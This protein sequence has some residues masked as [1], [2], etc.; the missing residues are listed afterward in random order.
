MIQ[1]PSKEMTLAF[2]MPG[3]RALGG[4]TVWSLNTAREAAREGWPT[5]LIEHTEMDSR[6]PSVHFKDHPSTRIIK[7]DGR[8][9]QYARKRDVRNFTAAYRALLPAIIIPN[10]SY[11]TY[12]TVARLI[13]SHP[14]K[15]RILGVAHGINPQ[16]LDLLAYYESMIPQFVAVSVEVKDELSKRLP[17]RMDDI[18][19]RSCPVDAPD[20]LSRD[21]SREPDPIR[22]LYAGRLTDYEKRVS[23]L[24]PLAE[25]LHLSGVNFCLRVAGIGGYLETLKAE[26]S[27]AEQDV[28]SRIELLGQIEPGSMSDVWKESDVFILVSD[29]EGSP[30]AML[31]A[32]ANGC[33]PVVM[34]V[35][36][37]RAVI[38]PYENGLIVSS[39]DLAGMASAIQNLASRREQLEQFGEKARRSVYPAYAYKAYMPWFFDLV[40]R[41]AA[42]PPRE[43]FSRI[44]TP[45]L[46]RPSLVQCATARFHECY[47]KLKSRAG[48]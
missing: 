31:E 43:C 48:I 44:Q 30:V 42:S 23:R 10:W 41:V 1:A 5:A 2:C 39:G 12:A 45:L 11:G 7:M 21:Y 8:T 9:A 19:V 28:Q 40:R 13:E 36:G 17:H 6:Y 18:H 24:V 15:T 14:D 37:V 16:V 46:P 27:S 4:T 29:A 35:S 33:V 38:R 47:G 34:D 32:M 20:I 22:L 3:G 25:A 26:I